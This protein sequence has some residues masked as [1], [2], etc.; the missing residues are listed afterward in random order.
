[1]VFIGL[2]LAY[3]H[4]AHIG[5]KTKSDVHQD[6]VYANVKECPIGIKTLHLVGADGAKTELIGDARP[7]YDL[8][9]YHYGK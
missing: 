8:L 2:H 3:G 5:G 9:N 4:S 7:Q 6:T 1:M